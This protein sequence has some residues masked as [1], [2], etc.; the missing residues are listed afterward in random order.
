M[1]ITTDRSPDQ[2]ELTRDQILEAIRSVQ[3]PEI[4]RG[5]VELSMVPT[6]ET[7][8]RNV[9]LTVELMVPV[10]IAPHRDRIEQDLRAALAT[11]P[12]LGAVTI[13]WSSR[14]RA[15]GSGK[16]DADPIK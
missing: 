2:G 8:G 13:G 3:E 16:S 12:D 5:L 15:S 6:V 1:T 10:A 11:L 7:D 14:V 9:A 4:G